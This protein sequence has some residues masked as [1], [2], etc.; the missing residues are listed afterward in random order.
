[1]GEEGHELLVQ[2]CSYCMRHSPSL[3]LRFQEGKNVIHL[4]RSLDVSDDASCLVVHHLDADLNDASSRSSS[5]ENF[6]D[7][8]VREQATGERDSVLVR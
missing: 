8:Y 1:M 3:T 7:L 2:V 6:D 5:S 4:A